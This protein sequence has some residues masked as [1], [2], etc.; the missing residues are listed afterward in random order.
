MR[1]RPV[2][3]LLALLLQH[4]G[5]AHTVRARRRRVGLR[6]LALDPNAQEHAKTLLRRRQVRMLVGSSR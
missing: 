5:G 4:A 1:W 2:A 3:L 6:L